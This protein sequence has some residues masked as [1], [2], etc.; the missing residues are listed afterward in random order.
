MALLIGF[1]T[2]P[3]DS[4]FLLQITSSN[5]TVSTFR[6][7]VFYSCAADAPVHALLRARM[8]HRLLSVQSPLSTLFAL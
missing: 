1:G 5:T 2:D 7:T 8:P 4:G 6:V 3:R